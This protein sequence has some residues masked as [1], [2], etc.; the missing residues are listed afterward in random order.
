MGIKK[1][2]QDI[3]QGTGATKFTKSLRIKWNGHVER[4]QSQ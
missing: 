4:M 1:E 2:I 3:L